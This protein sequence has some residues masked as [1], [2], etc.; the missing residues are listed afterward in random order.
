MD[1]CSVPALKCITLLCDILG[2]GQYLLSHCNLCD[3]PLCKHRCF[4]W[5]E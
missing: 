1:S 5:F 4:A 3:V 2:S